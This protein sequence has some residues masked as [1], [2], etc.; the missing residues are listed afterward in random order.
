MILSYCTS[1]SSLA[2]LPGRHFL[3]GQTS[4]HLPLLF[5]CPGAK[6]QVVGWCGYLNSSIASIAL[7]PHLSRT[8]PTTLLPSRAARITRTTS[9]VWEPTHPPHP[10]PPDYPWHLTRLRYLRPHQYAVDTGCTLISSP[11]RANS[12]GYTT[13]CL[14]HEYYNSLYFQS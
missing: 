12:L 6:G 9:Y 1:R 7:L 4:P 10:H 5:H 2:S 3:P 14:Q 11:D 13:Q 8:T